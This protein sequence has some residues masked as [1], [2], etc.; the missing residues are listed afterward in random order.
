MKIALFA[1][2][3]SFALATSAFAKPS[4]KTISERNVVE[5][6]QQNLQ[7]H[8]PQYIVLL[9]E[10]YPDAGVRDLIRA[11]LLEK[12]FMTTDCGP[13]WGLSMTEKGQSMSWA[14]GWSIYQGMLTIQVG[15][16]RYIPKSAKVLR[17]SGQGYAL[18]VSSFGYIHES[19]KNYHG[20]GPPYAV[21]FEFQYV[22][23][24]NAKA[25]LRIGPA[26]DWKTGDGLTLADAGRIYVKT[27][28]LNYNAAR[29]WYLS[30]AWRLRRVAVC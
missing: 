14:R 16:F 10:T 8:A 30:E 28:A 4:P 20:S 22:P 1:V 26:R 13:E 29:G 21:Q 15:R 27:V 6:V 11:G 17:S 19:G 18:H 7:D 25:L 24:A 3:A 23:N 2:A 9:D 12:D 5:V